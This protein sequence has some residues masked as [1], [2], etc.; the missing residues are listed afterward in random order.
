MFKCRFSTGP[1][2]VTRS[3]CELSRERV[4]FESTSLCVNQEAMGA[5][6]ETSGREGTRKKLGLGEA[7]DL[8]F[9]DWG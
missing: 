6:L 3:R 1:N 4:H 5:W 2:N 7:H 8:P 9:R